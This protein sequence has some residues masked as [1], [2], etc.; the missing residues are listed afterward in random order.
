M[1]ELPF[2]QLRAGFGPVEPRVASTHELRDAR[3]LLEAE[4]V[5]KQYMAELRRRYPKR[6]KKE[7]K[8]DEV[9]QQGKTKG[10]EPSGALVIDLVS[11]GS[12][13]HVEKF[14]ARFTDSD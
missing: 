13:K 14:L 12:D 8:W 10:A 4:R 2:R 5:D 3:E 6:V 11:S 1:T 7:H 9:Y